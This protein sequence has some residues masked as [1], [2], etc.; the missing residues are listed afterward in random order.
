[1]GIAACHCQ[2]PDGYKTPNSY[3]ES[4]LVKLHAYKYSTGQCV[5]T[6]KDIYSE[7]QEC[8]FRY[9]AVSNRFFRQ[10]CLPIQ[11]VFC[12]KSKA[13]SFNF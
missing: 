9:L 6:F 2:V 7:K 11:R 5:F 1:M 10:V 3:F 8:F 13:I 12:L 4:V